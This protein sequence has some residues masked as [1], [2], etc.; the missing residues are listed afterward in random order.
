MK[1]ETMF[2][3]K[4]RDHV[5]IK[6]DT[7]DR[8][9]HT[10]VYISLDNVNII[11]MVIEISF[12]SLFWISLYVLSGQPIKCCIFNAL[13]IKTNNKNQPRSNTILL[14]K[15]RKLKLR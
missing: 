8:E 5:T 1:N 14:E 6:G 4:F 12:N 11:Y 7:A 2:L 10:R 9:H 3:N 15:K 13:K